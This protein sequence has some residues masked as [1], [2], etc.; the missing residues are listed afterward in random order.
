MPASLHRHRLAAPLVGAVLALGLLGGCT[1][2][3]TPDSYTDS[4]ERNFLA[5]CVQIAEVD[6]EQ[7]PDNPDNVSD[8]EGYCQCAYDELKE[9]VEFSE[10]KRVN[11]D[12]VDQPSELPESFQEIYAGCREAR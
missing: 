10:F 3:S 1:G 4:V 2:Q 9:N 11:E 8:P 7:D 5:G 6:A 12:Q